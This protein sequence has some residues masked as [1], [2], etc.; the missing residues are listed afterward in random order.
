MSFK[1]KVSV[2]HI[3]KRLMPPGWRQE[4]HGEDAEVERK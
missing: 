3:H 2:F 4:R 1:N